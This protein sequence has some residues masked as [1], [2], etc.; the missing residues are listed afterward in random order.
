[1]LIDPEEFIRSYPT[2]FHVSL[3]RDMGQISRHGL[4]ST[5]ALLDLCEVSEAKRFAIESRQRPGTVSIHHPVHGEFLI[6]DQAPLSERALKKCLI[7]FSPQEWCETLNRRVFFWPTRARLEKHLAARRGPAQKRLVLSFD[8]RSFVDHCRDSLELSPIHSGNTMRKAAQRGAET[9]LSLS[10][11]PFQ[12]R[13]ARVG[14]KN[15]VAE[16]TYP[17]AVPA[18]RLSDLKMA[19]YAQL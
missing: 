6:N 18:S 4:L 19:I 15:A 2:L 12:E 3:A 9:F 14:V 1:M 7:D 5:S 10:H 16:V 17:Y 11:Y 8:T 13:K